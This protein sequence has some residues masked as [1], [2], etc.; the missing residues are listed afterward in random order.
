M[1]E[2]KKEIPVPAEERDQELFDAIGKGKKRRKRR[3]WLTAAIIVAVVAGGLTAAVIYG[4]KKVKE[5]MGSMSM[6]RDQ[7]VS[8]T[9]D[10]GSVNTTVTGSGFLADV[11][12][13]TVT[14]PKGVKVDEVL[15]HA[16]EKVEEGDLLATLD[17]ASVL[18]ALSDVQKQMKEL[19]GKLRTAASDAVPT[20]VTTG[21]NGRVK[22]LYAAAGDDVSACMAEHGALALLSLDGFMAVELETEAL[23]KD[24]E[25]VIVRAEGKELKGSVESVVRGK[26]VVLVTDNGPMLDEEITVRTADGEEIGSGT[27]Y[28]HSP[29]RITGFAGTV[30]RVNAA[31]NKQVWAGNSIY[32][33][34][35][36]AYSANYE[37]ILKDRR[38]LEEDLVQLLDFYR[39]GAVSAPFTGTVSSIEWGKKD[40]SAQTGTDTGSYESYNM[41][42]GAGGIAFASYAAPS[43]SSGTDSSATTS[44]SSGETKLLV[45]SPDERMTV[46]VPVDE[47]DILALEVGQGA[48]VT[49]NSIGSD[50]FLG[51]VTEVNRNASSNAGVT[52]YTV[53]I[54]MDK[55]PRML[56][57]MSAKVV[58]RIQGVENTILIPESALHQTR[59]AAFV[60][61]SYNYE[62]KEFGGAVPVIPGLS[63]GSMVE[64]IEGLSEGD[65]VYYTEVF[66]PWAWDVASGGDAGEAW[67]EM[68]DFAS[69][70][71]GELNEYGYDQATYDQI[72]A[73]DSSSVGAA[74]G[75]NAG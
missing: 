47:T 19:D 27:L 13:E 58:V 32:T 36:T 71:D 59:D 14:L 33:L 20:Y 74:S 8:Y 3:A 35:D 67:V 26:A 21:V 40:T 43:D 17:S 50:V 10:T 69:S 48:Q 25:V 51:E 55:D 39:S 29:L 38:E 63:N 64:I 65:T 15:V 24:Q 72:M 53:V 49:I 41:S 31:E 42:V 45:L 73:F 1:D 68:D 16:G 66:D 70:G 4:Q 75:G 57:G 6:G 2:N 54:T 11:D 5:Q 37:S 34:K 62:T 28:I 23:E 7:I 12:T 22:A 18:G 9:V 30:S 44:S 46:S 52:S 56:P 61:T 60:Y